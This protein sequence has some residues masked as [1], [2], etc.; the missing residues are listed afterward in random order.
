MIFIFF[1]IQWKAAQISLRIHYV[2]ILFMIKTNSGSRMALEGGKRVLI[3]V[4]RVYFHT[5]RAFDGTKK[6]KKRRHLPH[7][8]ELRTK[9]GRIDYTKDAS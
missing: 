2:G 7:R 8:K 4:N 1:S 6:K 9:K 3:A 5:V